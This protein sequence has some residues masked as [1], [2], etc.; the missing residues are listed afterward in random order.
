MIIPS[1]FKSENRFFA[2]C[3]SPPLLPLNLCIPEWFS[4]ETFPKYPG[5]GISM[6]LSRNIVASTSAGGAK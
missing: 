5:V 3:K 4:N 6:I 2:K 1:L